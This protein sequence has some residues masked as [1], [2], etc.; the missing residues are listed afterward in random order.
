MLVTSLTEPFPVQQISFYVQ[1]KTYLLVK[2]VRFLTNEFIVY[3]SVNVAMYF[4]R[5]IGLHSDQ[6]N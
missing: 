4:P 2:I 3:I 1:N 6:D 5:K